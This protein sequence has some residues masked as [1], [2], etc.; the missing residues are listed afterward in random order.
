MAPANR[1]GA[2]VADHGIPLL[3]AGWRARREQTGTGADSARECSTRCAADID[4]IRTGRVLANRGDDAAA[5]RNQR[6]R[7]D[8]FCGR[9]VAQ[10]RPRSEEHTSELQS[11]YVTP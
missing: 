10:R 11:P 7:V 1:S 5:S 6:W 3:S 8:T 9:Q 4:A 2:P